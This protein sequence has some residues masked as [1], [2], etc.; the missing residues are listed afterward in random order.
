MKLE[1]KSRSITSFSF[2]RFWW[3]DWGWLI[4]RVII[5]GTAIGIGVWIGSVIEK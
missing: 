5:D 1:S 3:Q 4:I 2:G